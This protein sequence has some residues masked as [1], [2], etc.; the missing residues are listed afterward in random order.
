MRRGDAWE[1]DR[2]ADSGVRDCMPPMGGME[3]MGPAGADMVGV[4]DI[5]DERG[6]AEE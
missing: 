4:R 6:A 3:D 1:G 2:E 5:V